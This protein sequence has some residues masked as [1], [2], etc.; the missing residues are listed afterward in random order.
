MDDKRYA[1]L[2]VMN[3]AMWLRYIGCRSGDKFLDLQIK[4]ISNE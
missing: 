4:L 1:V 3:E 2:G